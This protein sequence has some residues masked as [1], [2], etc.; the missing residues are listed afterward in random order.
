MYEFFSAHVWE[1]LIPPSVEQGHFE[2]I[3][4]SGRLLG[5]VV[6]SHSDG[7]A[8]NFGWVFKVDMLKNISP[9]I[10][11]CSNVVVSLHITCLTIATASRAATSTE[12]VPLSAATLDLDVKIGARIPLKNYIHTLYFQIVLVTHSFQKFM[13]W[14]LIIFRFV[15]PG[16]W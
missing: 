10:F 11:T 1:Q 5:E 13:N 14:S 7:L 16:L 3:P 12:A 6:N 15:P 9:A 4:W 8:E 2:I